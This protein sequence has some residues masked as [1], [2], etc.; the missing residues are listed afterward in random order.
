MD[1]SSDI[2]HKIIEEHNYLFSDRTNFEGHWQEVAERVL[3]AE[4]TQF[5]KRNAGRN[6]GEKRSEFIFDSTAPIA[7][8]RFASIMDSLITPQSETYH[9][10]A[11][12][13][14][15]VNKDK[16]VRTY[17]ETVNRLLFKYRYA[18][19]ANF[20]AQNNR[21]FFSIGAYGNGCVFTDA[22]DDSKEKGVRYRNTHLAET[23]FAENH[24]GLVDK[25][26]RYFPMTARQAIQMCGML[27]AE[28]PSYLNDEKNKE[29]EF[30][31]L[32]CVKPR[33]DVDYE[34][35]DFKGMPWASYY[36]SI[37]QELVLNEGG[38][39]SFPYA[40]ARYNQTPGEVY[41]RGP[42][43][44][45][46]PSIK[47]LNEEKKQVLQAGHRALNPVLML[48]DDGIMNRFNLA[49]GAQNF[50]GVTAD[51]RPL[52]H[53]LPVGNLMVG[54]E[55][56]DDERKDINDVALVNL[57]QLMIES[58]QK[59]A[60]EVMELA[61][62]K[63]ILIAPTSGRI[64]A[65]YLGQLIDREIDVLG[66]QRLIPPM[67]QLLKEAKGEY[68]VTY[69]SPLSRTQ[70]SGEGAGFY[71]VM[72]R[73]I[74]IANATQSPAIFDNFNVDAAIQ[75]IASEIEAVPSRWMNPPDQVAAVRQNRAQQQQEQQA[76]QALPGVAAITKAK[77][78]AS[79]AGAG[80]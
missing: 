29:R 37:Q 27:K 73:S 7:L 71:R 8:G 77:A 64:Q 54:K 76:V 32:H 49:P 35:K 21:N 18:P 66:E 14:P 9:F 67:P 45:V 31:F 44:E 11:T 74:E 38:Y 20:S 19:K 55:L 53:P 80:I 78:V 46:L 15:Q 1:Q 57:F 59:S 22:L 17:F 70:R 36:I 2:A 39:T 23:Y 47:T 58:P 68:R 79:K 13:N 12:S 42:M 75:E 28:V 16:D 63:G 61:R 6:K 40:I 10:L 62:E 48:F 50:G 65:E 30:W 4:R 56:M 52:V 3:P 72:E 24:Q 51:G 60:T 25:V 34:R 41:G 33:E 5:Q 43:M 69:N 26:Y